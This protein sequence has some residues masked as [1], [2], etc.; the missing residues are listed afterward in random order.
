MNL[1]WQTS[2]V[3]QFLH[4][5]VVIDFLKKY[6]LNPLILL[7]AAL[8]QGYWKIQPWSSQAFPHLV[9]HKVLG[10]ASQTATRHGVVGGG[11]SSYQASSEWSLFLFGSFAASD[12]WNSLSATSLGLVIHLVGGG[13]WLGGGGGGWRVPLCRGTEAPEYLLSLV[14]KI[15]LSLSLP[16]KLITVFLLLE[17]MSHSR[18]ISPDLLKA[19]SNFDLSL[20]LCLSCNSSQGREA[21]MGLHAF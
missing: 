4:F 7:W 13:L 14:L 17:D 2:G 8:P 1:S 5:V 16:L 3:P 9:L 19:E 11:S 15:L 18:A 10:G 12:K 21:E 20:L 6:I